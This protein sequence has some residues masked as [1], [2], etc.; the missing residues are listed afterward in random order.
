M[1]ATEGTTQAKPE[2][3]ASAEG[4]PILAPDPQPAPSG[5][6]DYAAEW[7]QYVA[8]T[9]CTYAGFL[10]VPAGGAVPASHPSRPYWVEQGMARPV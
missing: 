6:P 1:S 9:D 8:V 2:P 5:E 10:A 7:G 3:A 4:V